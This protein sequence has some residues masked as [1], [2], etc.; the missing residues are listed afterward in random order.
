MM[1]DQK[2]I[3][4]RV[5]SWINGWA[6]GWTC[7]IV[8]ISVGRYAVIYGWTTAEQSDWVILV[9]CTV[10]T[11]SYFVILHV[12][13]DT[14]NWMTRLEFVLRW[15]LSPLVIFKLI[16]WPRHCAWCNE[17]CRFLANFLLHSLLLRHSYVIR[18]LPWKSG[19]GE[20][21]ILKW[22]DD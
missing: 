12:I 1:H 18:Q 6:Q 9:P 3:K 8:D 22:M 7:R 2:N 4:L 21:M 15:F 20:R 10:Y 17:K 14:W 16:S 11:K 5:G 19:V 13:A